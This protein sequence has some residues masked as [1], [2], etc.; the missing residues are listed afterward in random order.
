MTNEAKMKIKESELAAFNAA[1]D[2]V[3]S[4]RDDIMIELKQTNGYKITKGYRVVVEGMK[5]KGMGR[6]KK[7]FFTKVLIPTLRERNLSE[8]Q[9]LQLAE[10]EGTASDIKNAKGYYLQIAELAKDIRS[11]KPKPKLVLKKST[12]AVVKVKS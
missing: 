1:F 6:E 2:K 10:S 8:D 11:A 12:N 4:D 5:T 9:I 7:S 3:G